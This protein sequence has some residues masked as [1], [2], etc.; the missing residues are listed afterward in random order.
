MSPKPKNA[1]VS[2]VKQPLQ[3]S[4]VKNIVQKVQSTFDLRTMLLLIMNYEPNTSLMVM[5]HSFLN[6]YICR[7]Y[8]LTNVCRSRSRCTTSILVKNVASVVY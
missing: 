7:M 3:S 5:I 2:K 8:S 4:V 1:R 6:S